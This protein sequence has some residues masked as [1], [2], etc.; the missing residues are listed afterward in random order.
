MIRKRQSQPAA[1][2]IASLSLLFQPATGLSLATGQ[3][4]PPAMPPAGAATTTP[5]AA[6]QLPATTTPPTPAPTPAAAP[7]ELPPIDGGWPR[8]YTLAS[9]GS[10]LVYQPQVASWPNQKHIAG[11]SVVSYR[12]APTRRPSR[13]WARSGLRPPRASP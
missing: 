9:G 10:I 5:A 3:G 12:D 7:A 6:Q 13:R 1:A 2:I 11:Y 4:Q 8:M